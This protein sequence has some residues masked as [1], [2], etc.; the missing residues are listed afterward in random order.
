MDNQNL[1]PEDLTLKDQQ[2]LELCVKE[3]IHETQKHK[4]RNKTKDFKN[5]LGNI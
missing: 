5:L 4:V 1:N 2:L 3:A